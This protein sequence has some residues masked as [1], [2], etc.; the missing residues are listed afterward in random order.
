MSPAPEHS[1]K[2]PVG[3]ALVCDEGGTIRGILRDDLGLPGL[4]PGT[5]LGQLVDPSSRI[6]LLNFLVELRGKGAAFDWEISVP[7][8][9][10]MLQLRLAGALDGK[11]LVVVLTH[12]PL[13]ALNLLHDL[14]KMDSLQE[15]TL[16]M[17]IEQTRRI[18]TTL[19]TSIYDEISRLNNELV[20]LQR[21][22]AKKNAELERS[23]AEIR[24]LN[25]EL[26]QQVRENSAQ[27]Q[28]SNLELETIAYTISHDLRSPLRAMDGF[29]ALLLA[30]PQKNMDPTNMD[31]LA[32]IREAAQRMGQLIEDLL[33]LSKV[34]RGDFTRTRVD[35]SALA[36]EIS[37]R[38]AAQNPEK[39]VECE[40]S[41]DLEAEGDAD[42]LRL[43]LENLL[44]NAFKFTGEREKPLV[45]FGMEAQQGERVYF[46]RD[47]GAG[48]NMSYANKLFSPFQRLH[49]AAEFPGTG[50][51][52]AIVERII[53]RHGGRIW[54]EAALEQGATF[55]FT[56]G[57]R[58]DGRGMTF[59]AIPAGMRQNDEDL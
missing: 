43:A 4:T 49:A 17:A 19:G 14:I 47:N 5:A 22:L 57:A 55:Y 32:R 42:L 12:S 52:L 40:I 25:T 54:A 15:A 3:T 13:F 45:R 2:A 38:L 31:Y 6:K 8:E 48:F 30:D 11:K 37:A 27:L 51:G 23:N 36:Q 33:N 46:V 34:T 56:L 18:Q 28:A 29:S 24:Q 50:I 10:E 26:Q 9:G 20:T 35:L 59:Q 53:T 7:K 44:G 41:P 21:E 58:G 16:R 39:R 1:G